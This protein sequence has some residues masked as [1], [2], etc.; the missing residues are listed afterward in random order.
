VYLG[1]A[2]GA[3][4][5][6]RLVAIK[7]QHA[8]GNG[9]DEPPERFLT[10]ARLAGLV[11]HANVVGMHQA[12]IDDEGYYFVCDYVEGLSL[13]GL[14]HRNG[15]HPLWPVA[16][17]GRV[18]LDALAGLQAVHDAVDSEGIALGM[19]HRDLAID[20]LLVGRDGMTR[21]ADFGIAKTA[22]S[23]PMTEAGQIRGK[24]PYLA[25]EYLRSEPLDKTFD[26][27]A[28]GVT[29]WVALCRKLPWGDRS[30]VQVLQSIL[31]EG[32]PRLSMTEP[33]VA[34]E[35][36]AVVA[37]ACHP[38]ARERFQSAREMLD[39]LEAAV[40]SAGPI[41]SHVQVAEYVEGV[42][43]Q[44]LALRR[45]RIQARRRELA[46]ASPSNYAG[47]TVERAPVEAA[48][49][50]PTVPNR[51]PTALRFTPPAP[52]P[53]SFTQ[54]AP[55]F[56]LPAR[57]F[58]P[59]ARSFTPPARSFTPPA[60][61]APTPAIAPQTELVRLPI[62]PALP[63]LALFAALLLLLLAGYFALTSTRQADRRAHSRG[64]RGASPAAAE[65]VG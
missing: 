43:G 58:T 12:G 27:Y 51:V 32:V 53:R 28:A 10:E 61:R 2:L 41:A 8:L 65:N 23:M 22:R 30:E 24:L 20:N 45:A 52:P 60:S 15:P 13:A 44:D 1:R 56:T 39:A 14:I 3:G 5:F 59:P 50:T 36:E 34:R 33:A 4:D 57:S 38:L 18:M 46:S 19:L 63:R 54:P 16:L 6:E 7:R 26:I 11:H 64:D 9:F 55:S 47:P 17:L 29:L 62:S 37:R 25:P 48:S 40:S 42:A 31:R 35:L 49:L 21:L